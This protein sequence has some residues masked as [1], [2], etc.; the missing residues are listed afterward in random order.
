MRREP[1]SPQISAPELSLDQTIDCFW[2]TI[3][4][5]WNQV[6]EHLRAQASEKFGVSVEQ[7]HILRHV[8]NGR[9]SVSEL[10]EVKRI[11]RPAISQGVDVLVNKGL[12]TRTQ[13]T[14]DR[15]FVQLELTESG[16]LLL[17]TVFQE[18]YDW[19]RLRL[20]HLSEA[21]LS[22]VVQ[23]ISILHDAFGEEEN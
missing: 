8:R 19:M 23:G 20:A 10:A 18:T 11:S 3:P 13:D 17:E 6:R 12:L 7:F 1:V 2:E 5:L 21:E 14:Q 16:R 4:P 15:R 9:G 22:Q